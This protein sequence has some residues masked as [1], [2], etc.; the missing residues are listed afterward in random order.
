MEH[1]GLF[2]ICVSGFTQ[3]RGT[4]H[5]ILKLREQLIDSGFSQGPKLRVWYLPWTTNWSD[6]AQD[7]QTVAYHT[8][9]RPMI[10]LCGYSYGGWGAVEFAR[11][12]AEHGIVVHCL[13]LCDPVARPRWWPRP[14]PAATSMLGRDYSFH[15]SIPTNVRK[16][17]EFYQKE[18]RPQGHILD[19]TEHTQRGKEVQLYYPH[20]L[21]DDHETFH[22]CVMREARGMYASLQA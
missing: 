13:T 16:V 6:V 4:F 8:G 20:Q 1:S 17:H 3:T 5:G 21:M 15:I 12:L 10:N 18:N 19:L 7:L 11:K 22:E 14:L 2:N 9:C